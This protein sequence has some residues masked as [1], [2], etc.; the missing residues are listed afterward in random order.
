MNHSKK[1]AF[2]TAKELMIAT[3]KDAN[4]IPNN[5]YGKSLSKE[6]TSLYEGILP[7]AEEVLNG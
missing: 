5:E 1:L 2:E 7:I 6:F 4:T 3:L